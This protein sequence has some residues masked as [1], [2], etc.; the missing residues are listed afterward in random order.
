MNGIRMGICVAA[1][2][3]ALT[4]CGLPSDG[5]VRPAPALAGASVSTPAAADDCSNAVAD[6]ACQPVTRKQAREALGRE[7][8]RIRTESQ[9]R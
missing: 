8:I 9:G 6:P 1:A 4:A 7:T 5:R 2:C 3:I